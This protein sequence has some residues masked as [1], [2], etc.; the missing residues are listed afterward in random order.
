ML[1]ERRRSLLIPA[2][3]VFAIGCI[4]LT[5]TAWKKDKKIAAAAQM[6]PHTQA[7]HALQRLTFGPRPGDIERVTAMGLDK[8]IDQQLHPE[9]IDDSALDA[10]L[11]PFRTLH[12][13]TREMVENFPP[14]P[15]IRAV[16]EGK[17]PMPSDPVKRAI[18]QAQI[19][20]IREKEERKQ[21][22]A[23]VNTSA[24]TASTANSQPPEN[25]SPAANQSTDNSTLPATNATESAR[26][27][28]DHSPA[29]D[30]K[31]QRREDKLYADLKAE[32]L[33]DKPPDE[34]MKEVLQMS[35][36][37]QRALSTSLKGPKGDEF[38]E[39]MN[40]KQKE[41]LLALNNPEQVVGD[42]LMQ[43]KLLRAI[44]G[45]RQL[46]EVMTDFWFN[47]FNVFI[48]K[49][50]DRYLV[51][52]YEREVIRPHALGKFEDLLVATAKSPAML[53]YLDNWLSVGPDSDIARGIRRYPNHPRAR[54]RRFPPPPNPNQAKAKKRNG[55]LNENYGR[56]LMELHTL[57]VN[58]GYT[59][60]DV[61]EVAR[62]L[63]GWTIDQ[64]Q[65]GGGFKYEERMHEPGTKIVLGHKIKDH[66]EKEGMEVLHILAHHPSTARF[67]STKLA[68]RFV[69]DDPP[70]ALVDRMAQTFLK[71]NGDIREVLETMLK[72][73]EFWSE[74]TYRAKVKTPLE[75][76]VSS[77]RATGADVTDALPLAR[78]L[79]QLGMPL[80]GMQPPTGY[81]MKE[82][83][84][85]NSSALLGRMNF[86][87]ALMSGK[88]RGVQV[89]I[90]RLL[91]TPDSGQALAALENSLL[92]GTVSKQT[93][94]AIVS[95]LQNQAAGSSNV[96]AVVKPAARKN[97]KPAPPPASNAGTIAGL[98]LGSPEFQRR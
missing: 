32:E 63:T 68:M 26:A 44:Y 62:V 48:G 19:E 2:A 96:K 46:D 77:I 3:L 73:P 8:W 93:H 55:G 36:D 71:K 84:W 75:F 72:S 83:T 12:M 38:L 21:E 42:E 33:L 9:H 95:E 16:M 15:V 50:A 53:F 76:V 4:S 89:D 17:K 1:Y 41:A 98:I 18:Y 7:L 28:A 30:R 27:T 81:S 45:E 43:A 94:D 35:P 25:Q 80:Y 31:A 86:S 37:E 66:G 85:V 20:R 54:P 79:N 49:G 10:R 64:P 70:P 61:T 14:G 52:S 97:D 69:S 92:A 34:R 78:Q 90:N 22:T 60:Q 13:D 65:K 87:L 24:T 51:T 82:E 29:D 47:H 40:P 5:A 39:G 11:A 56:E 23:A 59:Q 74:S 91:A 88:I 58:G 67:I 6:D 57:G